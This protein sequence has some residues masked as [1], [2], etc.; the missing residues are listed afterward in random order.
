MKGAKMLEDIVGENKIVEI[1]V[2][3]A[4][5]WAAQS[6]SDL[7]AE[8]DEQFDDLRYTLSEHYRLNPK[9]VRVLRHSDGTGRVHLSYLYRCRAKTLYTIF[10]G[11]K[12]MS[13]PFE[14]PVTA[15]LLI[16]G[17]WWRAYYD[18]GNIFLKEARSK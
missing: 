11:L 6:P 17:V 7:V 15:D 13:W 10:W 8:A 4:A 16:D 2:A 9:Q 1:V 12:V 3:W 5:G 14:E 18:G